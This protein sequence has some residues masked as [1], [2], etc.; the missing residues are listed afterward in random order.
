MARPT[1]A[2][3]LGG[4]L[5]TATVAACAPRATPQRFAS[6]LLGGARLPSLGPWA[7]APSPGAATAAAPRRRD[8]PAPREPGSGSQTT[9]DGG[10]VSGTLLEGGATPATS[11]ATPGPPTGVV[12]SRLAAPHRTTGTAVALGSL[13]AVTDAASLRAHVGRRDPAAPLTWTL[14]ASAAMR[15]PSTPEASPAT[16]AALVDAA[17][18]DARFV[19]ASST[20]AA[21]VQAGDL[22]V[23]D[24]AVGGAPASLVAVVLAVLPHG[25][26][27]MMYLGGGVV[28]RGL[29]SPDRPTG[30]RD[31]SGATLNTYLRHNRDYPPKGTRFLS[32]EL[33]LGAVRMGAIA[34]R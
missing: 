10:L 30:R 6:S 22:L 7:T 13:D 16:G 27:E 21:A 20:L 33:L 31:A 1:P 32:G 24:R 34:A 12:L 9:I 3:L 23:F 17:R 8:A 11:P 4:L 14:A 29:V 5:L 15:R 18:A 2:R 26:I 25:P 19:P 28:R